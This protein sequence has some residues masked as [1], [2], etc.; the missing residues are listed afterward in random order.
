MLLIKLKALLPKT[1]TEKEAQRYADR[2]CDYLMKVA[3]LPCGACCEVERISE[4]RAEE[5]FPHYDPYEEDDD[6]DEE[7]DDGAADE[8]E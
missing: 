5:V 8:D 2:V 7:D 6:A 3:D 1:C 4:R